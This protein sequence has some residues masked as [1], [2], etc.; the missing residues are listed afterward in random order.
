M[1][2]PKLMAKVMHM[3]GVMLTMKNVGIKRLNKVKSINA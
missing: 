1:V 3:P 2:M